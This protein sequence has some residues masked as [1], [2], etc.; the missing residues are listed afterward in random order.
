MALSI[1]V[2]PE[3]RVPSFSIVHSPKARVEVIAGPLEPVVVSMVI[4]G[5]MVKVSVRAGVTVSRTTVEF[6]EGRASTAWRWVVMKEDAI[7]VE[8]SRGRSF[9]IAKM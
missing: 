3:R 8:V 2:S 5:A 6:P 1:A 4:P 9:F 7:T